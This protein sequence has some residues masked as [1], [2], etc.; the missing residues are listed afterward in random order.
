VKETKLADSN[1][2]EPPK[3]VRYVIWWS[4]GDDGLTAFEELFESGV[5][6]FGRP[7]TLLWALGQCLK[8]VPYKLLGILLKSLG[9]W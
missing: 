1:P 7:A 4:S 9:G 8:S 2:R 6:K 5:E 3:I